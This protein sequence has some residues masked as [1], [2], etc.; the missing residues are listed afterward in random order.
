MKFILVDFGASRIKGALYDSAQNKIIDT[1]SVPSPSLTNHSE[2]PAFTVPL[3][4]YRLAFENVV[5]LLDKSSDDIPIYTCFEMH[6][7][8]LYNDYVSW[9]DSRADLSQADSFFKETGMRLK[10]GM[11]YSTLRKMNVQRA[12]IGTLARA[13]TDYSFGNHISLVASQG[14]VS[15]HTRELSSYIIDQFGSLECDPIANGLIGTVNIHNKQYQIYGGIGDLQAALLGA[16]LGSTSDIVINLGTGSQ[17]AKISMDLTGDLRPIERD[18]WAQVIT[19]IPSGRAL[20]VI[21]ELVEPSRFW[22]LWSKLTVKDI[23]A[24]DPAQVDLNLFSSSWKYSSQTGVIKLKENQCIR[25][26]VAAVAASWLNQYQ[27]A[28]H[29]LDPANKLIRVAVSG[30]MAHKSKF[31]LDYFVYRDPARTYFNPRLLSNEETFDGLITL[32]KKYDNNN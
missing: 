19:H 11:A 6:G 25:Q 13:I 12:R 26:F 27:E 32:T 20:D 30:G 4:L 23:L 21:A 29:M 14:F 5:M 17:V 3:K 7:F 28:V 22:S 10:A 1:V 2:Y 18:L 9:K 16:G 15:K 24:A 8:S 31:V